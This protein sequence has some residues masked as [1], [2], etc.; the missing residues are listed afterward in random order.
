MPNRGS[1]RFAPGTR[2]AT[3]GV[4]RWIALA[5]VAVACS[6][7]A[8]RPAPLPALVQ[9]SDLM[10][11][12]AYDERTMALR[13][14]LQRDH[15]D[16]DRGPVV[17]SCAPYHGVD[18]CV[19]C[20]IASR[21]DT[22]GIDPDMIDAVAIAFARYPMNVLGASN[23]EHVS[24]CRRI[25]YDHEHGSNPAGIAIADE[26]RLMLSIETF[27]GDFTLEQI[28]HHELFH[29]IDHAMLGAKAY[30]DHEWH[31][32]NP[33]AFAYADPADATAARPAGFV[34]NYATT[35]ELEDRASV[36]EY[37]M[38]QPQAL[39]EIMAVDPI[40]RAK[41]MTIRVR[42]GRIIGARRLPAERCARPLP[43]PRMKS[44]IPLNMRRMR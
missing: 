39:C 11:P 5:A 23:L 40:V 31:A 16:L 32:L 42:V 3:C 17:S 24:L 13:A 21:Q 2:H 25:R 44:P 6:A 29:L 8:L 37:V 4:V 1:A 19:R 18:D 22:S 43:A 10:D 26:K 35:N 15:I 33:P 28:V 41:V 14:T 34:N 20:E 36:F 30:D 27:R 9:P 7:P 38:G 12:V